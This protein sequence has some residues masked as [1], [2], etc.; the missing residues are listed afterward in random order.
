MGTREVLEVFKWIYC[1]RHAGLPICY[2]FTGH[3]YLVQ[4][5][6]LI[7]PIKY[8]LCLEF[9]S[10]FPVDDSHNIS[11]V[12]NLGQN[13]QEVS[14]HCLIIFIYNQIFSIKLQYA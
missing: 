2:W 12:N 13:T 11:A 3:W 1:F 9:F 5:E 7:F 14:L 6:Y 8:I 10:C 4:S